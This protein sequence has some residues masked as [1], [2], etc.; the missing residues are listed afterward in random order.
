MTVGLIPVV[1]NQCHLSIKVE[2][3]VK[4]ESAK[5]EEISRVGLLPIGTNNTRTQYRKKGIIVH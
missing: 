5:R 1:E 4:K 2:T 3:M